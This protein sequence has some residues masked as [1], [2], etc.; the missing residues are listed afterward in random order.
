VVVASGVAAGAFAPRRDEVAR[1][2]ATG[3]RL[4]ATRTASQA[5]V[6]PRRAGGAAALR[7]GGGE[8]GRRPC[9]MARPP[10][11]GLGRPPAGG[12]AGPPGGGPGRPPLGGTARP[13]AGVLGRGVCGGLP[14]GDVPPPGRDAGCPGFALRP[15]EGV[16]PPGRG[17]GR[18]PGGLPLPRFGGL[19]PPPD[20]VGGRR[21][22]PSPSGGAGSRSCRC[23]GGSGSRRGRLGRTG[24]SPPP[25]GRGRVIGEHL[26][27]SKI[28]APK[29]R[30][31]P[32]ANSHFPL[33][34][35]LGSG[36]KISAMVAESSG[37]SRRRARDAAL[38]RILRV[39]RWIIAAAA[40]ATAGVAALI[41]AV[42]PGH[43]LGASGHS[44]GPSSNSAGTAT[45]NPSPQ[46][47]APAG[48]S[49]LGLQGPAQ[50]PSSDAQAPRSAPSSPPSG[51]SGGASSQSSSAPPAVSGGS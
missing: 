12:M 36:S 26:A 41:S 45:S 47:P 3:T 7:R 17:E 9:G 49:Q 21:S 32:W 24:S 18:P 1:P 42:A 38:D 22:S 48:A 31:R 11:G 25:A 15:L 27:A 50:P 8:V 2:I 46:M 35:L 51:S 6:L 30:K 29:R 44:A 23:P 4:A 14:P 10:A 40:A 20:R 43:T 5:V 16:P 33:T 39:R 34:R 13:P 37:E 28:N 19:P